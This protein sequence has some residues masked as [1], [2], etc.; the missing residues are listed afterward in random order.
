MCPEIDCF[1]LSS[2]LRIF[3]CP[4]GSIFIVSFCYDTKRFFLLLKT[5]SLLE[6]PFGVVALVNSGELE[7]EDDIDIIGFF[8]I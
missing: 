2:T 3:R 5:I 7:E 4:F 8:C 1:Y 6:C